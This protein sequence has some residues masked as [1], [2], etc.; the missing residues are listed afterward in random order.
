MYFG[1]LRGHLHKCHDDEFIAH[2]SFSRS[3]TIEAND[4]GTPFTF[5]DVGFEAFAVVVVHDEHFLIGYHS[6]GV[7]EIFIYCNA[8]GVV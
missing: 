5:D 1:F 6:G 4:S 3:G 7:D 2:L 8:T